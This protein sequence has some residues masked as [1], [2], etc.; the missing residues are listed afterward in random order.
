MEDMEP[1][2]DRHLPSQE[3]RMADVGR[4][5]F[6]L[7]LRGEWWALENSYQ[8]PQLG[9][10]RY[11]QHQTAYISVPDVGNNRDTVRCTCADDAYWMAIKSVAKDRKKVILEC[12][13][14]GAT[15]EMDI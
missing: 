12:V 4:R 9:C 1:I 5:E 6:S 10:G 11:F 8:C 2:C 3:V 15:G 14:C 13:K 7:G